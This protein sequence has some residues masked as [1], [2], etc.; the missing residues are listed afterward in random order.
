MAIVIIIVVDR[1]QLGIIVIEIVI[2]IDNL[3]KSIILTT[4]IIK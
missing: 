3:V 4:T 1:N 2:E